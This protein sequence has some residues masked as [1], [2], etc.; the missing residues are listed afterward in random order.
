MKLNRRNLHALFNSGAPNSAQLA[1]LG[2]P[3]YPLKPG[4]MKLAIGKEVTEEF[5]SHLM[6]LKGRKPRG[7]K[8]KEWR[9]G[10]K[11]IEPSFL[12]EEEAKYGQQPPSQ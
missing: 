6:S 1:L 7:V 5:Y 8:R 9:K 12:K 10:H 2:L 4:W 11:E 3:P